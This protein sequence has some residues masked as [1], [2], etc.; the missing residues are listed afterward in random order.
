MSSL[1]RVRK[2]SH[3][4]LAIWGVVVVS[5]ILFLE[6]Y[7]A[8]PGDLGTQVGRW[9]AQSRIQLDDR[10]PNLLIFLHPRCSCSRASLAELAYIMDRCRDRVSVH[11][12]LLGT[13]FL[14]RWGQSEIERDLASL[15][16]VRVY[17]DRE[18]VEARRFGVATS[19]HA[20]LYDS[21]GQLLFSGGITAARG[22][23]GDNFGR[24]AVLDRI[25][26]IKGGRASSSVFGCPLRTPRSS[27]N[28]ECR[29]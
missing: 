7:A 27:A 26:N 13:T 4:L 19:G 24:A 5:G 1:S 23:V 28:E 14:D 17:P 2:R 10:R 9:L 29:R 12:V 11:A 16:T 18:G 22:H 25:L 15:P 6:A 21:G 3:F 20:L 8:R